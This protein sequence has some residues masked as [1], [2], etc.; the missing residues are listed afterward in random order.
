MNGSL[1]LVGG[2]IAGNVTLMCMGNG[3][4]YTWQVCA[5]VRV[6]EYM[7]VG[8]FKVAC[9]L[10]S[11][12]M[13]I[14]YA[15]V[16]IPCVSRRVRVFERLCVFTYAVVKRLLWFLCLMAYQPLWVI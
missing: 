5:L 13:C 1:M 14:A 2:K 10:D 16:C 12:C 11:V 8:A 3:F 15:K 9:V 6:F 7:P 4:A